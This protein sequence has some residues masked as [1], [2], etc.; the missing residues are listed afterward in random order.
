MSKRHNKQAAASRNPA[1]N[2]HFWGKRLQNFWE[3]LKTLKNGK[4]QSQRYL[5]QDWILKFWGKGAWKAHLS[6]G[7]HRPVEK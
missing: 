5:N 1:L 3:S 7:F 2:R 4:Q 6:H